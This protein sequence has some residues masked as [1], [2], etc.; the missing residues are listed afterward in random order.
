[1][2]GL[3][4]PDARARP[5]SFVVGRGPTSNSTSHIKPTDSIFRSSR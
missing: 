4:E 5:R 1:M 3:V 2:A